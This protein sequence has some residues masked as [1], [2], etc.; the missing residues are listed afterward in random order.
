M[1]MCYYWGL[2]IGH[3]YTCG[4][5]ASQAIHHDHNASSP[6]ISVEDNNHT[7][8]ESMQSVLNNIGS[9][10]ETD[11]AFNENDSDVDQLELMLKNQDVDKCF[12]D[13][14]NEEEG[15]DFSDDDMLLAMDNMY[16]AA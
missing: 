6:P 16:G 5:T 15:E 4:Q 1:T 12:S 7:Y 13:S 2:A 10:T 8:L 9:A 3:V 11:Q 14:N